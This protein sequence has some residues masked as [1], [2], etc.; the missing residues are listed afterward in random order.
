MFELAVQ[1]TIVPG[2]GVQA[3]QL[4]L[5]LHVRILVGG[6]GRAFM[7]L[8]SAILLS[9]AYYKIVIVSLG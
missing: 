6:D 9:L 3:A 8:L 4:V 2:A 1:R 7:P 5:D